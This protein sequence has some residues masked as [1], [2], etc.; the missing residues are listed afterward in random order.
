MEKKLLMLESIEMKFSLKVW[1]ACLALLHWCMLG[2]MSLT[3]HQLPCMADLSL[4]G[5][6]L[7]SRCQ[8]TWT[9]WESF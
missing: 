8:S 3:V 2:G 9:T 6:L 4:Q 5:A 1:M 7:S